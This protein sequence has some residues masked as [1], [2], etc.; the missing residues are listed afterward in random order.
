MCNIDCSTAT[1]IARER[2]LYDP[3]C[4]YH[5]IMY[6]VIPSCHCGQPFCRDCGLNHMYFVGVFNTSCQHVL[7]NNPDQEQ[8]AKAKPKAQA[9]YIAKAGAE[10]N[11]KNR[12]SQAQL[13]RPQY[14]D[15]A[16]LFR[17]ATEQQRDPIAIAA[18]DAKR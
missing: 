14:R 9:K 11:D 12:Q 5:G 7:P 17:E 18:D 3:S 4:G 1:R 6:C 10:L 8:A 16:S 13:E 15:P 2:N